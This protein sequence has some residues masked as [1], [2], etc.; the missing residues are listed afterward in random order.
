M[1]AAAG[2]LF[3]LET[4]LAG[5]R[6]QGPAGGLLLALQSQPGWRTVG[7]QRRLSLRAVL[8]AVTV[9][10]VVTGVQQRCKEHG[11]GRHVKTC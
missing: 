8:G 7:W 1:A 5:V 6:Q 2:K 9:C 10:V 3:L 4:P 11:S